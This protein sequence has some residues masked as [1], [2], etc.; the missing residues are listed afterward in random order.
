MKR[1]IFYLIMVFYLV[2][3][4]S[5][6]FSQS[7][8]QTNS[9]NSFYGF[10]R[11]PL[12]RENLNSRRNWEFMRLRNPYTNK[13]PENISTL[14]R[15]YA[16][17]LPNDRM[18]K[19]R[20]GSQIFNSSP[21]TYRGPFNQGGRSR[22][23]A[24]DVNN[25]NVVLAGG[26]TGGMWRSTDNGQSWTKV[27][28]VQDTIQTV[29]CIVQDTRNGKT[30]N[31]YYGTGEYASNLELPDNGAGFTTF[32]GGGIYKSTDDGLTWSRLS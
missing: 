4:T 21:W 30:N 17:N 13:I 1:N 31:W 12:T 10:N 15:L 26:A 11:I 3:S 8:V 27:T 22:A 9:N 19:L 25:P 16:K 2:L 23:I 6:I 18:M 14:E 32:L 24:V 29:T 7:L 28:P 5:I 20:K